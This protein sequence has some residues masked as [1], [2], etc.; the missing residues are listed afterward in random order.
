M[1]RIGYFSTIYEPLL[2]NSSVPLTWSYP[3]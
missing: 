2:I 1:P 3:I